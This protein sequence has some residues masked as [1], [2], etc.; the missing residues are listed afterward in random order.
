M[1]KTF[2]S[3]RFILDLFMVKYKILPFFDLFITMASNTNNDDINPDEQ[4]TDRSKRERRSFSWQHE[5]RSRRSFSWQHEPRSRQSFSWQHEPRSGRSF[6]W[7]D[8]PSSHRSFKWEYESERGLEN[9]AP[10]ADHTF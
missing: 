1:S 3:P 10:N 7:E 8:E 9:W 4:R 2:W 6:N 5:P